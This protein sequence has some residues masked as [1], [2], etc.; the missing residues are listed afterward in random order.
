MSAPFSQR[1][2]GVTP[3]LHSPLEQTLPT[4]NSVDDDIIGNAEAWAGEH[5]TTID[6]HW[7]SAPFTKAV[8]VHGYFYAVVV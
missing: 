4:L 8:Y 3:S 1:S 7:V 5:R 6:I 2:Y